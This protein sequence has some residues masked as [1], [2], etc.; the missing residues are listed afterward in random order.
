[1]FGELMLSGGAKKQICKD[2]QTCELFSQ[3]SCDLMGGCLLF[4]MTCCL[5]RLRHFCSSQQQMLISVCVYL[6]AKW[7]QI[8]RD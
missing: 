8:Y 3:I 7:N 1:M 5:V 2:K 6:R 4:K